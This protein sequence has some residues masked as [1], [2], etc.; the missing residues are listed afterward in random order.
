MATV[1]NSS[2]NKR[3]D[4]LGRVIAVGD[5]IT[6]STRRGSTLTV[7]VG[8]VRAVSPFNIKV[9]GGVIDSVTE[10][11]DFEVTIDEKTSTIMKTSDA[12]VLGSVS[13]TD[14]VAALAKS[15]KAVI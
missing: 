10:G 5:L 14:R 9:L 11:G 3:R 8:Y 2:D 4:M 1:P 13:G 12:I 6:Y 7:K 15:F